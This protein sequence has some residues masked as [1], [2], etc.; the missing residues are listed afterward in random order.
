MIHLL[1]KSSKPV[2]TQYKRRL[3][4]IGSTPFEFAQNQKG[5]A[6]RKRSANE[7]R[8]QGK[9]QPNDEEQ[10]GHDPAN[11]EE[12]PSQVDAVDNAG[13][14]PGIVHTNPEAEDG[15]RN[16]QD[17]LKSSKRNRGKP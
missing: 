9:K 2:N 3:V 12:D 4:S 16:V 13:V 8:K 17:Q 11:F 6:V 7:E 5:A 15:F 10:K 1:K 14:M